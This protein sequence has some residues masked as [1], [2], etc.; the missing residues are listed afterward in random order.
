MPG[1]H[2]SGA[3]W[4]K[5][6]RP[7]TYHARLRG[8]LRVGGGMRLL[9]RL[10][11]GE[12]LMDRGPFRRGAGRCR[13]RWLTFLEL[14][15]PPPVVMLLAGALMKGL[16]IHVPSAGGTWPGRGILMTVLLVLGVGAGL[17]GVMGFR[18]Q[19]TTVNPHRPQQSTALVTSGIYRLSRNPMYLG[20]VLLLMAW[21][22]WL[23]S[24]LA[25]GVGPALFVLFITRFQII[26]EERALQARFGN[27]YRWYAARVRRWL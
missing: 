25:L 11:G 13:R 27:A 4:T 9:A 12:C 16:A 23:G 14:K 7:S 22:T 8:S 26:P 3:P 21:A 5:S 2:V 20:M 19:A 15:I 17:A 10:T 6:A 18:R 24:L 1:R